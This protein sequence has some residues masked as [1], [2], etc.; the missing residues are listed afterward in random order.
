MSLN[1]SSDFIQVLNSIRKYYT[2]NQYF[3]KHILFTTI[4]LL[5][6]QKLNPNKYSM[7]EINMS[8]FCTS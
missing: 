4:Y 8:N 1:K 6:V 7:Q 2:K 3:T 5:H